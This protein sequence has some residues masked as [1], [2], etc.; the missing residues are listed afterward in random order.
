[1]FH[2]IRLT[3]VLVGVYSSSG[4]HASLQTPSPSSGADDQSSCSETYF[5]SLVACGHTSHTRSIHCW[6]L[7]WLAA[8]GCL[9]LKCRFMEPPYYHLVL[10]ASSLVTTTIAGMT[11][12]LAVWLQQ[13]MALKRYLLCS[14]TWPSTCNVGSVPL[15][16]C[17]RWLDHIRLHH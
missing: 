13:L 1:M 17:R 9:H 16:R 10:I 2:T 7:G 8:L 3:A 4:Y 11:G 6:L 14:S 15:S 12:L 5:C